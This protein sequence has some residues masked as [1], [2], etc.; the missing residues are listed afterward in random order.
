MLEALRRLSRNELGRIALSSELGIGEAS[1]KTLLKRLAREGLVERTRLGH[2][3]TDRGRAVIG[4]IDSV[5]RVCECSIPGQR[6]L[7]MCYVGLAPTEPPTSIVDVYRLRD[8]IVA[9]G[10][11]VAVVGFKVNDSVGFP[12]LP[13]DIE[14]A[15][16]SAVAQS[17]CLPPGGR[18]AI[19][20][21]P[22]RCLKALV[23]GILE[24][25]YTS[26]AP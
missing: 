20:I 14:G 21:V 3:T 13:E 12:G 1:S 15:I 17:P 23:S 11:N 7:D 24:L 25:L 26:C 16:R 4:L 18:G 6:D 19:I 2:V 5:L 10:C 9:G 8:L 22:S